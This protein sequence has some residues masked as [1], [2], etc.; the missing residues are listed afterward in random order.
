MGAVGSFG[1]IIFEVSAERISLIR[2]FKRSTG[3]RVEEHKV[4][5]DKARLEFMA[6]ELDQV[7]F[8]IFFHAAH[9]VDPMTEID[10]LREMCRGGEVHQLIIGGQVLGK[11][12]LT[13]VD[14][15]WQRS[16]GRG[17]LTVATVKVAFKEYL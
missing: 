5:G 1:S 16:D 3:V 9:G 10:S 4:Q 13:K 11:F 7:D 17:K 14:E 2:G 12:L 8:D 15:D 6:P